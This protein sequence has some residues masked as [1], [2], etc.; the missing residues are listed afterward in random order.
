MPSYPRS[1][2]WLLCLALVVAAPLAITTLLS[3]SE[4]APSAIHGLPATYL[5]EPAVLAEVRARVRAHDPRLAE[6]IASLR[7][8]AEA[9]LAGPL[10]AVTD[11]SDA[12]ATSVGGK[13]VYASVSVYFWPDPRDPTAP[14]IKQDGKRNFPAIDR[15]DGP[16]IKLLQQ[17]VTTCALAAYFTGD[18]RFAKRAADQARAWFIAPATRMEPNLDYAQ[19]VPNRSKGEPWGVIDANGFPA[20]FDS[21]ELLAESG[22][23]T[24]ADQAGLVAWSRD[25]V[26]WLTTSDLGQRERAAKNNH[27]T[28]YDLLL[29]R[30]AL[31]TGNEALARA[32]V[33][34]F[35]PRRIATQI[36]PDGSTPLEQ[37]RPLSTTYTCWNLKAMAEMVFIGRRLGI[38][39]WQYRGGDGQKLAQAAT[40]LS[41]YVARPETW[42]F[43]SERFLPS[44][45]RE[46]YW[47]IA[48]ATGDPAYRTLIRQPVA[49]GEQSEWDAARSRLLHPLD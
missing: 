40:W 46:F 1:F 6:A 42:N 11:K 23:W 8:Q 41:A 5:W 10:V 15:F 27:G 31:A 13:H 25:F 22:A 45:P 26:T 20:M 37:A 36:Q 30:L 49:G 38:D 32:V 14:W 16:R 28:Y 29:T 7:A 24:T 44:S 34:D 48:A 47:L 35:G 3:A 43:G 4:P 9:E 39:L 17:R 18:A 12:L 21:L 19:C 33:R 2:S